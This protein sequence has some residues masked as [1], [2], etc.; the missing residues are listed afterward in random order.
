MQIPIIDFN[1]FIVGDTVA[2]AAVAEQIYRATNEI[3]FF[4]LK[5]HGVPKT[6]ITQ[7]FAQTKWFFALPLEVK[8]Q[9]SWLGDET[10]RGYDGLEQQRLDPD[11]P[12]ELRESFA[13]SKEVNSDKLGVVRHNLGGPN[14][15]PPDQTEFREVLLQFF[16]A[17]HEATFRV[18]QAFAISLKLPESYFTNL[19]TLQNYTVRLFHYPPVLQPPKPEQMRCGEHS[20]W[21]S[22]TLLFQDEAQGL[23]VCTTSGEWI[24]ASSIPDTIVVN[25]GDMMQRWTNDRLRSTK[26]RVS[27]PTEFNLTKPR[28]SIAFFAVPNFNAEITCIDSHLDENESPKYPPILT[29]EY[30]LQKVRTT[31][32]HPEEKTIQ[33]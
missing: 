28:Y 33:L 17:C 11:K 29:R 20:D 13:F 25:T 31:Y 3:G 21:G 32:K 19:H 6:L 2:R 5:N 8:N 26:H 1:P 4:Y 23:E 22:I 10:N 27:I 7:A 24:A 15:W 18:L 12:G 9:L 16:N 30:I 14:K